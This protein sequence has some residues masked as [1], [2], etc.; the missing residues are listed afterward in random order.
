[1][2]LCVPES[3]CLSI[4]KMVGNNLYFFRGPVT[5]WVLLDLVENPSL[6][7]MTLKDWEKGKPGVLKNILAHYPEIRK[8]VFYLEVLDE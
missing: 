2:I 3:Q 4:F 1:M 7:P 8:Y 6:H 5:G